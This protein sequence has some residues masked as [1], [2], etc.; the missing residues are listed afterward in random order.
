MPA[1]YEKIATNT[2]GSTAS[3]VIFSSI[4][5]TYTDLILIV[6]ARSTSTGTANAL[7]M[8][9]NSD[10]GTNYGLVD[11]YGTGSNATN[12]EK[13]GNISFSDCGRL[14]SAA[15]S[16]TAPG[17]NIVHI[18]IYKNTVTNKTSIARSAAGNESY[19]TYEAVS[20]WRNN[21]A[22]TS[23]RLFPTSDTFASGSTFTLYG[24]LAA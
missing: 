18:F 4:P 10:T 21:A 14:A 7:N 6:C 9:Y 15:S 11:M 17:V 3:E 2:L 5:A 24:I 20:A 8:Q 12:T 13:Y 16:S 23:I 22:I 1:T 19:R